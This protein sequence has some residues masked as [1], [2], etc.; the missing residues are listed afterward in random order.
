MSPSPAVDVSHS[1]SCK[2]QSLLHEERRCPR[3]QDLAMLGGADQRGLV[4]GPEQTM[5]AEHP[6]TST[7]RSLLAETS[8]GKSWQARAV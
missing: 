1:I 2:S 4:L 8:L 7:S 6:H 3:R 5:D